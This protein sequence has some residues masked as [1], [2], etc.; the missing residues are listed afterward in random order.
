V[1]QRLGK[2]GPLDP[3]HSLLSVAL[4]SLF[5][6]YA[7]AAHEQSFSYAD[8]MWNPDRIDVR[9]SVHRDDA[10]ATLGIA[11]PE[12]L[13]EAA[14][15]G[16]L[17]GRLAPAL[18]AG[19][20]L[21]GDERDL[22][23]R[24]VE[25]TARPEERTISFAFTAVAPRPIGRVSVEANVF[26]R[27]PQHETFLNVYSNGGLVRQEVLTAARPRVDVYGQ[28]SPGVLAVVGTFVR[29]GIHHI[30]IGPDHILFIVGLLL[31]G[32]DI[33]RLLRV[34]TAFTMAH[35]ITLALAA[36]GWVGVP[37]RVVEPLIAL[38]IVY[39]GF[40]NL[41]T[42]AG[43][44]DWRT[45]VAFGFGLVHGFGFA[46]V[47]RD[48]G[49]PREALGWSLLAFNAGVE[50][51]QACIVLAVTPLLAALRAWLPRLAPRAL[52]A[53]SWAIIL[54]GAYWFVQR[55]TVRV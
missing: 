47:L 52:A 25:A 7:A 34:A 45:R 20:R 23:L 33:L 49:L 37:G 42:S 54:V 6:P 29:A 22:P 15:L 41:R 31:L 26:P 32:G 43:G 8:L 4:L 11:A 1:T 46:G 44:R 53:G 9:L 36:L 30:F 5:I 19:F 48:F 35:S 18:R 3:L 14:F 51:G 12:S 21:R 2:G 24:F 28:G 13:M 55:L 27:I 10:A 39:V 16:R 17:A 38:S 50:I 40:E